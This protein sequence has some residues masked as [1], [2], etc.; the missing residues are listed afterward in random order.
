[1]EFQIQTS[2]KNRDK[3]S[4][5]KLT[6]ILVIVAIICLF[7]GMFA[8]LK[9][10]P[11]TSTAS[12]SGSGLNILGTNSSAINQLGAQSQPTE[13]SKTSPA[14]VSTVPKVPVKTPVPTKKPTPSLTPTS[15]P[16]PTPTPTPDPTTSPTS[17][18]TPT[19]TPTST[20]TPEP[21]PSPTPTPSP[22]PTDSA[23]PAPSP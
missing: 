6:I 11:G 13:V 23:S 22:S 14:S 8:I 5:N 16:T 18:P 15:S 1:M 7:G 10:V 21:T 19:P 3:S 17:E 12:A 9:L 4:S 20:P 2:G